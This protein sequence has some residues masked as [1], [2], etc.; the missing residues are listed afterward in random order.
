MWKDNVGQE[1]KP[2][3]LV[4]FIQAYNRTLTVG[5]LEKVTPKGNAS[6]IYNIRTIVSSKGTKYSFSKDYGRPGFVKID[7]STLPEDKLETLNK[8]REV[9]GYTRD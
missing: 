9:N 6:V 8:I 7:G 3:D 4:A 1:V 2:G 5:V